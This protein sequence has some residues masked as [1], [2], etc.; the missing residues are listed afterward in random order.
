MT[1][2]ELE[3]EAWKPPVFQPDELTD[4]VTLN[5]FAQFEVPGSCVIGTYLGYILIRLNEIDV[6]QFSILTTDGIVSFN[7]TVQMK[8][9]M[10][11]TPGMKAGVRYLGPGEKTPQGNRIK[12]Y[13]VMLARDDFNKLFANGNQPVLQPPTSTQAEEPK[14]L[15]SDPFADDAKYD[16]VDVP[17]HPAD[18]VRPV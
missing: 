11:L 16:S 1:Q 6:P 18:V 15:D 4:F 9:L 12:L 17:Q 10:Y 8:R 5:K 2:G 7:G 13:D 3:I 14:L